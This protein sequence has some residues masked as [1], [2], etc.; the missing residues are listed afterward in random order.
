[1]PV[2]LPKLISFFCAVEGYYFESIKALCS[3][4]NPGGLQAIHPVVLWRIVG[5]SHGGLPG[6][7]PSLNFM[8][9]I[10]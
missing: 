6:E 8:K 1:M 5:D 9:Y 7:S 3:R 2:S 10:L 4:Q